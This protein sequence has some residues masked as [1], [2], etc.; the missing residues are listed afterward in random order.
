MGRTIFHFGCISTY[1]H[2]D[3]IVL[4]RPIG[5]LFHLSVSF[6][7]YF[8]T[9]GEVAGA[10]G[11]CCCVVLI[12]VSHSRT[13]FWFDIIMFFTQNCVGPRAHSASLFCRMRSSGFASSSSR[14]S[15]VF[16]S[17]P[18]SPC[19]GLPIGYVRDYM[20]LGN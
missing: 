12:G 19:G 16:G 8:R 4:N 17:L 2:L 1:R 3:I 10:G 13:P 11:G 9:Y 7:D 14:S 6:S 18:L 5:A 15:P 20:M